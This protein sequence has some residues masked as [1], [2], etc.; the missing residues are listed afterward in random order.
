MEL[1][2]EELT[3]SCILESFENRKIAITIR[4]AAITLTVMT[5]EVSIS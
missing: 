5:N 4:T 1:L 3:A 2:K